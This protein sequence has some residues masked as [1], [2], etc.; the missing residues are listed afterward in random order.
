MAEVTFGI[1]G[2]KNG[3]FTLCPFLA[4]LFRVFPDGNLR[5]SKEKMICIISMVS[6]L[7]SA[8]N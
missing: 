8:T 7:N 1:N 4:A 2:M 6:A 5:M 3:S